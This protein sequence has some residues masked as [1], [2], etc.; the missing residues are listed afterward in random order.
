MEKKIATKHPDDG[1]ETGYGG[2]RLNG[3]HTFNGGNANNLTY[4]PFTFEGITYQPGQLKAVGLNGDKPV[5]EFSVSTPGEAEK[6]KIDLATNGK[7]LQSDGDVIFVYAKVLDKCG[8]LVTGSTARVTLSVSKNATVIS[9][10]LVN[11]EAG[12]ATFILRSG[13]AKDKI[14][15]DASAVGLTGGRLTVVPK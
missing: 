12:I 5:T 2:N 3:G 6:I 11:A 9:P 7:A 1:P 14:R 13:S 10:V 4:P 15:L 8:E